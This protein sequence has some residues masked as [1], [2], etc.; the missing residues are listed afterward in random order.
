MPR[1]TS[2]KRIYR[3][4]TEK[5]IFGVCGGLGDYFNLDPVIFRIFFILFA[6]GMGSGV[7]AYLVLA[8]VIPSKPMASK[9]PEETEK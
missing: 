3:S 9:E 4:D 1:K 5:V 2:Y 8:L 6:F 7:L